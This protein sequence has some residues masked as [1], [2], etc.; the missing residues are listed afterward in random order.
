MSTF[1]LNKGK[2]FQFKNSVVADIQFQICNFSSIGYT[3][4]ESEIKGLVDPYMFGQTSAQDAPV[5]N[6]I[7]ML[8]DAMREED[9]PITID[10]FGTIIDGV[11]M[12]SNRFA[13]DLS[14]LLRDKTAVAYKMF[15]MKEGEELKFNANEVEYIATSILYP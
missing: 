3:F 4:T 5:P 1:L 8:L 2:C 13:R 11:K 12:R 7:G 9:D 10:D 14:L 6:V 15:N